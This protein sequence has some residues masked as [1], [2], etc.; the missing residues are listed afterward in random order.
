[1]WSY[2]KLLVTGRIVTYRRKDHMGQLYLWLAF[3]QLRARTP[4]SEV[5]LQEYAV[6]FD[7]F[8]AYG[9]LAQKPLSCVV[10]ATLTG[11]SKTWS[12][13]LMFKDCVLFRIDHCPTSFT[14]KVFLHMVNSW[15]L[16]LHSLTFFKPGGT[17]RYCGD[18]WHSVISWNCNW[19]KVPIISFPSTH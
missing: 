4:L 12:V 14:L 9:E 3:C 2:T 8:E 16:S 18:V 17:E 7:D 13:Q 19:T 6:L 1:M 5:W 11:K 10:I 15:T